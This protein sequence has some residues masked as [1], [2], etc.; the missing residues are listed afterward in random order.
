M[1]IEKAETWITC[2]SPMTPTNDIVTICEGWAIRAFF[3]NLYK[4]R[5]AFHGGLYVYK[6]DGA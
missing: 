1:L 5:P 3:E 2:E 4:I 6:I